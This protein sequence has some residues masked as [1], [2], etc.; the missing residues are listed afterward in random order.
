MCHDLIHRSEGRMPQEKKQVSKKAFQ[1]LRVWQLSSGVLK[2]Y[3]RKKR[4]GKTSL[5]SNCLLLNLEN[6]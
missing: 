6:D 1:S 3:N 2:M 4:K 5:S